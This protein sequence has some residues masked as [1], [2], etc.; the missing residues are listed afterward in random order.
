ML[1]DEE[2]EYRLPDMHK[3]RQVFRS[4]FYVGK[5]ESLWHCYFAGD[6]FICFKIYI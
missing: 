4:V 3:V 2:Y 1:L 5:E 6:G